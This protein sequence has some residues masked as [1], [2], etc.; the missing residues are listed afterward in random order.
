MCV[1]QLLACALREIADGPLGDAVLEVGIDATKGVLLSSI[2]AASL[3]E[4]VVVEAPII[5][6]VV[7]LDPHAMLDGEGLEGT[8]GG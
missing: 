4:D 1:E 2:V 3:L 7:M 5:V 8:L 6:A